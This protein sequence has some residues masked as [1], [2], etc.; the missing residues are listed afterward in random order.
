MTRDSKLRGRWWWD[1]RRD[2]LVAR[3]ALRRYRSWL[4][5]SA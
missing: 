4:Q 5:A 2:Q 1:H 3:R